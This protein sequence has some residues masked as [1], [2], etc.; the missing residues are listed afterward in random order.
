MSTLQDFETFDTADLASNGFPTLANMAVFD[1][2][3]HA[4]AAN[5]N[6][7]PHSSHPNFGHLTLLVFQAVLEVVFVALPGFIVA[8]QGMFDAEAQKFAANLNVQLFTPCL[9]F[10]KLAS[11][12]RREDLP[13]LAL[14]PVI[15]V[16][17]TIVSYLC[18]RGVS[19]FCGFKKRP[20]NFVIAMAVFG[21]S[22]SLPI[23]LVTSLAFT[24]KGLHWS[25]EPHDND[26]SVSSRGITY[27]VLF[28]QLGQLL[29]WSWG[30]RVLL[31][32]PE[33]YKEEDELEREHRYARLEG[34]RYRD[35]VDGDED[36]VNNTRLI[37]YSDDEE[38]TPD[39][40]MHNLSKSSMSA[41]NTPFESGAATPMNRKTYASSVSTCSTCEGEHSR[42]DLNAHAN[43]FSTVSANGV[44]EDHDNLPDGRTTPTRPHKSHHHWPALIETESVEDGDS[45]F[46]ASCKKA[47]RKCRKQT[48]KM[49]SKVS[50]VSSEAFSLLPRP[51]QRFLRNL[52][53][54]VWENLNPPLVA[55]IAALPVVL[56]PQ[57]KHLLFE[58][59]FFEHSLTRAIK[60]SGDVAVPLII[61]VLGANLARNTLPK[62]EGTPS[63]E[64]P[65]FERKLLIASLVARML[66]PMLVMAPIL[67]LTAKFLPVNILGDPI[68]IIVCYLLAG[69][70]SALQLA[71]ICQ[72]NNVYMGTMTRLLFHS[73]VIWILP[74]TL[75]LVMLA[76]ETLEWANA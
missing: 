41:L 74:S 37:D 63:D 2:Y 30:Y 54:A 21:N 24:I 25:K 1:V 57:L 32:P 44:L 62:E 53:V 58:V 10:Y 13:G 71:Q 51:L 60:Q 26:A 15:F 56:I 52:G 64:D 16:V 72:I 34:G 59:E 35:D 40:S 20:R 36:S 29:R 17:Q 75:V 5:Q 7:P 23:S 28:Q 50:D 65:K 68:F 3:K 12:L 38:I 27:L 55:M 69:A 39:A 46:K 76:L 11:Q 31:A 33:M 67:T 6:L 42:L 22:N 14:I 18:A 49:T 45:S 47:L 73:Y 4:A 8:R 66:L 9:I 61:V 43:T 48:A 70:P 19:W